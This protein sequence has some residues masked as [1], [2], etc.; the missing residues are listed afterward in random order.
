MGTRGG[1]WAGVRYRGS[2]FLFWVKLASES[3]G[4]HGI[5]S[6]NQV[7]GFVCLAKH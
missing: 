1:A 4:S 7:K 5:A 2:G 6:P 3:Y